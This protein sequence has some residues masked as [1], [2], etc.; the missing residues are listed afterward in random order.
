MLHYALAQLSVSMKCLK[1]GK[2]TEGGV[3]FQVTKDDDTREQQV[4]KR[5]DGREDQG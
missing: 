3:H 4:E 5:C 1:S 2:R